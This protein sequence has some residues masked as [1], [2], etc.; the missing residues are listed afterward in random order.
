MR[1]LV[2]AIRIRCPVDRTPLAIYSQPGFKGGRI[3]GPFQMPWLT[4]SAFIV[5]AATILMVIVRSIWGFRKGE[6][7]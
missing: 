3:M 4:F 5:I 7:Q 2:C 6:D 1:R